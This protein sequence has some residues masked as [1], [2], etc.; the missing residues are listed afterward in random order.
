MRALAKAILVASTLLST[1]CL[2]LLNGYYSA[3]KHFMLGTTKV[4]H[5]DKSV[6]RAYRAAL[7]VLKD[8][9]YGVSRKEMESESAMIRANKDAIEIVVDIKSQGE[10]S[11]I[12][13][14][15]DTGGQQGE[16]WELMTE[17]RM[18]P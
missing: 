11:E 1:G 14:E 6:E 13:L 17:I 4:E 10:G 16:L 3:P 9:G 15:T 18:M 2:K 12:R 7:D 8:R 5:S